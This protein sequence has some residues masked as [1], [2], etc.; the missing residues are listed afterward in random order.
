MSEPSGRRIVVP[1]RDA[2][3]VRTTLPGGRERQ[4]V[5]WAA[6]E[7]D[8]PAVWWDI[9][10]FWADSVNAGWLSLELEEATLRQDMQNNIRFKTIGDMFYI[11][12]VE[13]QLNLFF[14]GEVTEY[15][16]GEIVPDERAWEFHSM[17]RLIV[18]ST[19]GDTTAE[20]N[21]M[22]DKLP[23]DPTRGGWGLT[24]GFKILSDEWIRIDRDTPYVFYAATLEEE[25]VELIPAVQKEIIPERFF[26]VRR[27]WNIDEWVKA[28]EIKT[29]LLE[30]PRQ[31]SR[32]YGAYLAHVA[33]GDNWPPIKGQLN[34]SCYLGMNA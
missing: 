17:L 27:T 1:K 15:T 30:Q 16:E 13:L 20:I 34:W 22:V 10:S 23:A 26:P 2:R 18:F 7:L 31:N 25:G 8:S 14:E 33:D 6:P 32:R 3:E 9:P 11:E 5:E 19:S 12:K 4:L 28:G 21:P 24:N 29:N